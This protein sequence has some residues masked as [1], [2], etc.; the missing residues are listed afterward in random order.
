MSNL[1]NL[2]S[3]LHC[4]IKDYTLRNLQVV[5]GN[6]VVPVKESEQNCTEYLQP[7]KR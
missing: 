7:L 6:V 4:N 2:L 3:Q 5:L 1:I